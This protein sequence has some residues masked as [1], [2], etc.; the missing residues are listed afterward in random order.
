MTEM[1]Q[2]EATQNNYHNFY[3]CR[4]HLIVENLGFSVDYK[5]S[6]FEYYY[7]MMEFICQLLFQYHKF[8]F[9]RLHLIVENLF[10][11]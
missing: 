9:C 7:M 6:N 5:I 4:L 1:F 10:F 11:S 8:Y 2:E 3:F